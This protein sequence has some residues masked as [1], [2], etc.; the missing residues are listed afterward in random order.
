VRLVPKCCR[1]LA[2]RSR[3]SHADWIP[4]LLAMSIVVPTLAGGQSKDVFD[5]SPEELKGVQVYS[6]SMYLQS[7]REAPASVTVITAD[8]I[9][10]FGYRTLADVLR[11]V[12]GFDVT[13]D[14]NYAY[15]GVRG[16]SRP[17]SYNDDVLLLIDGH[18]LNDN[19]YNSAQIGTEFPLDIDLISRIEIV[20][21]PSSSL[22][23]TSAL[24][25]VINVITKDVQSFDGIDLSGE[26]GSFGY[27]RARS[28]FA[29]AY[30]GVQGLFS[31]TI[32]DSPGSARL[33]FPAYD[34]ATTNHGI[35]RDADDDSSSS[36][37]GRLH[38]RDFTLETI[39][40]TRQKG[41]PT[42]SFEQVFNDRR[43]HT[44]DSSGHLELRYSHA[45]LHGAELTASAYYDRAIYH[46][47]YVYP[48]LASI[49]SDVLNLDG[50]RG[51]CL[52]TAARITKTLRKKHKTTIGT[53]FRDNPRQDQ[54]NYNVGPYQLVLQ[55]SRTSKEWAVYAQD[56]FTITRNIILNA[57]LRH[58]QYPT[59]GGTTNPRL[60]LI[61]SPLKKTTFKLLYGQAFRAPNNYELYYGD[62]VSLE[63]NQKLEPESIHT[64][65]FIWEQL[66]GANFQFTA[67]GF[68]SHF[69][70]LISQQTDLRTGLLVFENSDKVNTRGF[71][72]ELRGRMHSGVEG[73]V[74][75]MVQRTGSGIG[76]QL[77]DS[78]GHLLKANLLVPVSRLRLTTGFELQYDSGRE[79]LERNQLGG[80]AISNVTVTSQEFARGYRLSGSVYNLFNI[81]YSDPV[82]PDILG[83][84]V[85]QDGREFRI[86]LTRAFRFR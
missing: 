3:V 53:E 52:G 5:L 18:R 49:E 68:T 31:G 21:G 40:S 30:H 17:G 64:T 29:G 57:G 79:T 12:R 47:V 25:A 51:D 55:D 16:F 75:Y 66:V 2:S 74:S 6:A 63:P 38:L 11:S 67:S 34:A 42:A 50:S 28:T 76:A 27:Y 15:V 19:V 9:R 43:S 7:D 48:P 1:R 8:Q 84:S 72:M 59:F 10:Q 13:Y 37:F 71:E 32:Y 22:Y 33:F 86:Q 39:F 85:R 61:Y 80:Y 24:L 56:E 23:G 54:T 46:A 35:A 73:R 60:A 14:R 81:A 70:N 78:P 20:R 69:D 58:D 77:T 45:V 4:V 65:E 82:G 62:H 83:S 36:F 26:A 41:I 44:V